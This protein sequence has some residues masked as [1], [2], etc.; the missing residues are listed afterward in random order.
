MVIL[1]CPLFTMIHYIATSMYKVGMQYTIII[2]I[3]KYHA[4]ILFKIFIKYCVDCQSI[5]LQVI[6]RCMNTM[7]VLGGKPNQ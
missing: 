4:T 6:F 2:D 5:Y 7:R 1:I 3:P